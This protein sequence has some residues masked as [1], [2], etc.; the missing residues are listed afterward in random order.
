MRRPILSL[1]ESNAARDS[2]PIADAAGGVVVPP[3]VGLGPVDALAS[4]KEGEEGDAI[5]S[6]CGDRGCGGGFGGG[7]YG[8][9][10]FVRWMSRN[11]KP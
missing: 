11:T 6:G 5:A 4:L 10:G 2:L 3:V 7:C 1:V 8:G 9:H